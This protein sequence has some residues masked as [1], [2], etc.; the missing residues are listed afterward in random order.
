MA[1]PDVADRN[2]GILSVVPDAPE[3]PK[4][5]EP[6]ARAKKAEKG[7]TV[8]LAK[9]RSVAPVFH[10]IGLTLALAGIAFLVSD[11][12]AGAPLTG[13]LIEHGPDRLAQLARKH[14]AQYV[15]IDRQVSDRGLPWRRLFPVEDGGTFE[16]YE[17]P[18]A[19]GATPDP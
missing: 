10:A 15:I 11:Y 3:E 16:L 9:Q 4:A 6:K 7:K 1:H 17:V 19:A 5:E 12:I 14:D 13:G 8:R 18:Q 2:T